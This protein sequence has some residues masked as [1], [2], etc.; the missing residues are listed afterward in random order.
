MPNIS[1]VSISFQ[2]FW[3]FAA[4]TDIAA[5]F[6]FF[7]LALKDLTGQTRAI[8]VYLAQ[9]GDFKLQQNQEYGRLLRM[10]LENFE[11]LPAARCRVTISFC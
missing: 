11:H 2:C 5:H 10:R 6:L 4:C 7:S 9:G 3:C 8:R 1:Q